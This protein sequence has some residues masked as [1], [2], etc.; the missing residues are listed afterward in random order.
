MDELKNECVGIYTKE[1]QKKAYEIHQT[2]F[3][4]IGIFLICVSF[5][6]DY[7]YIMFSEIFKHTDIDETVDP[8]KEFE[9]IIALAQL[10]L[11][12]NA[13]LI[14][15]VILVSSIISILVGNC[16]NNSVPY[17]KQCLNKQLM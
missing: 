11:F 6:L 4:I 5:T 16:S 13:T 7:Y 9:R 12:V 15:G 10:L 17:C 14:I 8:T 1:Y 2:I 3:L